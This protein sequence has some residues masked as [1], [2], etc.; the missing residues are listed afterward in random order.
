MTI[1]SAASDKTPK[2]STFPKSENPSPELIAGALNQM[3]FSWFTITTWIGFKRPL[4]E[5][6]IYDINPQFASNELVPTFDKYFKRSIEN[7]VNKSTQSI[8]HTKPNVAT[9]GSV[10][11][12]LWKSFGGYL[13]FS[14]F[15]R[16][17]IDL[18]QFSQPFLLGI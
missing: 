8:K 11:S 15:L 7:N 14:L 9:N 4:I 12:A 1:L 18:I 5:D 17:M 13:M 16:I 3:F 10:L 6:D 2:N